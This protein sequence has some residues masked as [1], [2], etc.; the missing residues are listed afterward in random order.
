MI[1]IPAST[2]ETG[3]GN[4]PC[5][6]R[7][8]ENCRRASLCLTVGATFA[9]KRA[10]E[11]GSNERNGD[12][13]G[14]SRS[15]RGRYSSAESRVP[16]SDEDS[17]RRRERFILPLA[18]TLAV[19]ALICPSRAAEQHLKFL[20]GLKQR[21]YNNTALEYLKTLESDPNT[22]AD[23]RTVIPYE[24]AQILIQGG[25]GSVSLEE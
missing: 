13:G 10:G 5:K 18:V 16:A 14:L 12:F 23:V 1:R 25:A 2:R 22:P 9:E 17:M 19:C 8:G 4:A 20:A 11:E 15:R 7:V 21:G 24:R 3:D 6:T